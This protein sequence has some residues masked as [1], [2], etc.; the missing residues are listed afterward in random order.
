MCHSPKERP[1]LFVRDRFILTETE[2]NERHR[3]SE[4]ENSHLGSF[5]LNDAKGKCSGSFP[6]VTPIGDSEFIINMFRL[7]QKP[8]TWKETEKKKKKSCGE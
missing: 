2:D 4:A 5:Q 3:E 7:L 1:E 6:N 8:I